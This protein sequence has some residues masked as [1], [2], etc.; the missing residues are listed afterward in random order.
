M[1]YQAVLIDREKDAIE[2]VVRVRGP[3]IFNDDHLNFLEA[4]MAGNVKVLYGLLQ[5][6]VLTC[7]EID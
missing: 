1:E 3:N 2:L 6:I 7:T 5:D 4:M